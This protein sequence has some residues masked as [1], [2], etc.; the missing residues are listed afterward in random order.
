MK[1]MRMKRAA[2]LL[3]TRKLNVSEVA[4][5]VGFKDTRYFSKC[6][7]K[8]YHM[9]PSEYMSEAENWKWTEHH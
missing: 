7:Q 8:Q 2:Q 5:K 3:D 9:T 4:Y 6:F 1:T